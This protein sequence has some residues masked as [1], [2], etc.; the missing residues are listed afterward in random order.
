MHYIII[1][2][3][4]V[5]SFAICVYI[6]IGIIL[7]TD[8]EDRASVWNYSWFCPLGGKYRPACSVG[9]LT[10]GKSN[11]LV[12]LSYIRPLL[13]YAK[14]AC[15]TKSLVTCITSILI[16]LS[17]S[18]LMSCE[19]HLNYRNYNLVIEVEQVEMR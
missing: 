8:Q 1:I 7:S 15:I 16:K 2:V 13:V 10:G 6:T 14:L 17:M 3:L 9:K 18:S 19:F 11:P 5:C 4:E 12:C